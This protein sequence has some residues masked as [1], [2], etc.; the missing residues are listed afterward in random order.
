MEN[1]S[2]ALD[3][4]GQKTTCGYCAEDDHVERDCQ[5][6]A[7]LRVLAKSFRLQRRMVKSPNEGDI[8][9]TQREL[10]PTQE[11]AAKSFER[12]SKTAEEKANNNSKKKDLP[13]KQE[14][15]ANK[16]PLS[17]SSG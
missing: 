8:F 5:K 10:A 14:K 2:F 12:Q 15:E 9:P 17:N 16:R 11:E 3:A 7:H 6:K 13:K 1:I 4:K